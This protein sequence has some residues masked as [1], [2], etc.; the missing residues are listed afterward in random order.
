MAKQASWRRAGSPIGRKGPRKSDPKYK[1]NEGEPWSPAEVRELRVLVKA[2]TPTG[3]IS[4]KLGRSPT[5]VRSKA[6]R[7][8]ISLRPVNR[9]PYNRKTAA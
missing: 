7:E 3:V 9:S 5:A 2:N 1:R 6:Q 4:L 8:S